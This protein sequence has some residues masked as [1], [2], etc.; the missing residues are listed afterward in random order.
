MLLTGLIWA[1]VT[2]T[3]LVTRILR[4]LVSVRCWLI[5]GIVN[6][7]ACPAG[8][9]GSATLTMVPS[10]LVNCTVASLSPGFPTST[11]CGRVE[12]VGSKLNSPGPMSHYPVWILTQ[13]GA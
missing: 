9:T 6:E 4:Q 7:R 3:E 13:V 2:G 1:V 11:A 10:P 12:T 8:T 5:T